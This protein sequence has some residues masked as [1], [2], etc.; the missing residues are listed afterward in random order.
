MYLAFL[1]T[2][3]AIGLAKVHL[4]MTRTMRQGYKNFFCAPLLFPHVIGHR[5]QAA[6]IPML[7]AQTFKNTFGRVTLLF[8]QRFIHAQ[9]LIY[10]TNISI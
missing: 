4:C 1:P 8:D 7:I 10:H 9:D 5:G 6:C 2:N 3:H